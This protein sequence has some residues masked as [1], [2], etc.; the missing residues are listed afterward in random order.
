MP[1]PNSKRRR[2]CRHRQ[3]LRY[4]L[5]Q[6]RYLMKDANGQVI[7]TSR[8]LF[9]RVAK[10]IAAP[11][12]GYGASSADIQELTDKF[13][14][15]MRRGIFLPN[16]PTLMNAGRENGMCV[17]CFVL[18]VR[19]CL[20]G[21]FD[22]I[23]QTALIQKVGGGTGFAF[24]ELRP[25]G[26]KVSSCGGRTSGPISF[27]RVFSQTTQA[28]QQGAHRRGANMGMM[29]IEHPDILKFIIAKEQPG[30]FDNFN[31]SVKVS[32]AWMETIKKNPDSPHIVTN[33]RTHKRYVLPHS[34]DVESYTIDDLPT[35]DSADIPCYTVQ[36]I[37]EK[38]VTCAWATG[39]PGI[40]FIDRV[41]SDNPTPALGRIEATNP[42]GEQPLLPYECCT[43]GSINVSKFV[44]TNGDRVKWPVLAETVRLAVRFLDHVVDA[45][46]YPIEKIRAQAMGNRKIGLGV[47]GFAD[48]LVRLG[49]RYDSQEA[50][51]FAS[52]IS[53]FIQEQANDASHQLAMERESF[54]NWAGSIWDT[55][56]HC[57]MRNASCTTIAPTGSISIIAGCSSGIEP[58]YSLAYRRRALDGQEF[59]EIHPLLER[60]GQHDGWMSDAVR[61]ALLE[62]VPPEQ[63]QSIP[64]RLAKV[65]VTAH[66]VPPDLHVRMQAAFQENVDNAVSKTVN[67]PA[68]ASV[69]MVDKVF[70]MAFDLQ[71]KGIT[72]YRDGSR[73]GQT[74]ASTSGGQQQAAPSGYRPRSR[75]STTSGKTTK[76]R[77]G[78]GTLFVTV[79][80]DDDGLCE[81]FA[82]LGKAGGCPSQCGPQG[83]YRTATW[84]TLP[85]DRQGPK[86]ERQRK[87]SVVPRC[88]CQGNRRSI[89]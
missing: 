75:S 9:Y 17:A 67:L 45:S 33:P 29:S 36:E 8:Q 89:G 55:A 30:A 82:N 22:S 19:D 74:F 58:I 37:W 35:A 32:N 76:F 69:E 85:F 6:Q 11:E 24:D 80:R 77:M 65:L 81:V 86:E 39:E 1:I 20:D 5:M 48:A 70:R 47:M 79:N 7:E 12:A 54:P 34:L 87:C 28:I 66:E 16:T 73:P 38:I 2:F 31:L 15:L 52:Q 84:H 78:C 51:D 68:D 56:L 13:F 59:T 88:H 64:P 18:P 62:D 44:S 83:T 27:M 60:T 21:I 25:T 41:N 46:H 14:H 57:P 23:T 3:G 43:L 49:I 26:D 71:C 10:A 40:C 53:R 50:L 42:C 63:I 61:E 72:V 4:Q